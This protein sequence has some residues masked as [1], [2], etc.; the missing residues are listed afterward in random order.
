MKSPPFTT[1]KKKLKIS[2]KLL[3]EVSKKNIQENKDN[4]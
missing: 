2:T 1:T 3:I 4:I